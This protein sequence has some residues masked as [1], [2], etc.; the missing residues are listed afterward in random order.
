MVS[1]FLSALESK[2]FHFSV[3]QNSKTVIFKFSTKLLKI[4]PNFF[5][6]DSKDRSFLVL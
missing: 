2:A 6:L 5:A 4:Y 3:L 1:N